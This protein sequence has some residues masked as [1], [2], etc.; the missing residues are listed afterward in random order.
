MLSTMVLMIIID[1]VYH[2][3]F[4]FVRSSL[5]AVMYEIIMP[6]ITGRWMSSFGAHFHPKLPDFCLLYHI[7]LNILIHSYQVPELHFNL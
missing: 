5:D 6:L 1:M 7:V 4:V 2:V 3:A